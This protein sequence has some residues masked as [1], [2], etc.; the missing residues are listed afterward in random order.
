MLRMP[1]Q[2]LQLLLLIGGQKDYKILLRS[3]FFKGGFHLMQRAE[4]LEKTL[5]LGKIEGGRT[6][7]RQRMRWLDGITDSMDMFAQHPGVGD[8]QGSLGCCSPCG[9]NESD[10]T[11]RLNNSN[12][13]TGRY[14]GEK[15][16]GC[17]KAQFSFIIV[18]SQKLFS[19][20]NASI[21]FRSTQINIREQIK[22]VEDVAFKEINR[23]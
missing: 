22:V 18:K 2:N 11:Q 17:R 4:S 16:T 13:T 6:R 8:G 10:T 20:R 3:K 19:K 12:K 5:M 15:I 21:L 1:L 14:W 23:D 7:G 9:C